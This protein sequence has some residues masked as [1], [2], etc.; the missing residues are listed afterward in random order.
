[1]DL[2]RLLVRD[3]AVVL[4]AAGGATALHQELSSSGQVAEATSEGSAQILRLPGGARLILVQ[5]VE[6]PVSQDEDH[7]DSAEEETGVPLRQRDA[8]DLV[9]C[10]VEVP[11]EAQGASLVVVYGSPPREAASLAKIL[12]TIR[13]GGRGAGPEVFHLVSDLRAVHIATEAQVDAI[14]KS[15]GEDRLHLGQDLEL[16]GEL[17]LPKGAMLASPTPGGPA[18][19]SLPG[20]AELPAVV[21]FRLLSV[22]LGFVVRLRQR[23]G[24]R[25][26]EVCHEALCKVFKAAAL[27]QAAM[28][29]EEDWVAV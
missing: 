21:H 11:A 22:G 27:R 1:M 17:R 14:A 25:I 26:T 10:E 7:Q 12:W 28:S 5:E 20:A 19:G 16:P 8:V 29:I 18:A 24:I 15:L 9:P 13:G 4:C 2:T 6:V 3:T 23:F